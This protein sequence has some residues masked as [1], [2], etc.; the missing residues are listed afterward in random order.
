M[1]GDLSLA[2]VFGLVLLG[3]MC[4]GAGKTSAD[5][6]YMFTD[7]RDGSHPL[8][9]LVEINGNFYGTTMGAGQFGAGVVYELTPQGVETVIHA[10]RAGADGDGPAATLI[11]D[12]LGNLYGTAIFEGDSICR[13][14]IVYKVTTTGAETVL[15]RF[16]GGS[17]GAYPYGSVVM[18]SAGNLYGTTMRGGKNDAGTL[19]RISPDGTG[20]VL[21]SFGGKKDGSNPFAGPIIDAK[22]NVYGTTISGGA[23]D[24]GTV[25]KYIAKGREKVLY[26]FGTTGDGTMPYDSLLRDKYGNL[27]GTAQFGGSNNAGTVFQITPHGTERI[28]YTFT[29]GDDGCMPVAPLMRD[30]HGNLFGTATGC[31]EY[32]GTIFKIDT[33]GTFQVVH[34]FE[35]LLDGFQP[36]SGLLEDEN[37]DLWG[38]TWWGAPAAIAFTTAAALS[39]ELASKNF[40]NAG[41]KRRCE[42]RKVCSR[43]S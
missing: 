16:T 19:F 24:Q 15:H 40:G 13:C 25:W 7:G 5:V 28:L 29:G 10:F 17:D 1:L 21:H 4:L 31:G 32:Y 8:A 14:G 33:A 23:Y 35:G 42:T 39:S 37:G 3:S 34:E 26:S 20:T 27:Y 9:G 30:P 18:D 22:G 12:G 36:N 2:G 6:V 41:T 11:T 43:K 38:T